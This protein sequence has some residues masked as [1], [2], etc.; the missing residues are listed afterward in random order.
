MSIRPYHESQIFEVIQS[1]A[2]I[3]NPEGQFY[4]DRVYF[5]LCSP[6]TF[7]DNLSFAHNAKTTDVFV[8]TLTPT[9]GQNRSPIV[10]KP[11]EGMMVRIPEGNYVYRITIDPESYFGETYSGMVGPLPLS[12]GVRGAIQ[13]IGSVGVVAWKDDFQY[14]GNPREL[15]SIASAT[16]QPLILPYDAA[17]VTIHNSTD[18]NVT[19]STVD[20]TANDNTTAAGH[21][22]A[23]IPTDS[24]YTLNTRASKIY[25]DPTGRTTGSVDVTGW[26][27]GYQS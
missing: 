27:K 19:I 14:G 20:H 4:G 16:A 2:S 18:A 11:R 22:I 17:F 26:P 9:Q 23:K 25:L 13:L 3:F 8:V 5:P 7:F 6:S 24:T 10:I 21:L 12:T 1:D 15:Y